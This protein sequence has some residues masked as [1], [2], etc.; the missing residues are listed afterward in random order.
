[1]PPRK[2]ARNSTANVRNSSTPTREPQPKSETPA[3]SHL[4]SKY[5]EYAEALSTAQSDPWTD[6]EET[7]LLKSLVKWKPTGMCKS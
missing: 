5:S 3:T 4:P 6:E 2:R 1:M 7:L